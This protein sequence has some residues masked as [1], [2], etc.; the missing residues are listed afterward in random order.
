MPFKEKSA[1]LVEVQPVSTRLVSVRIKGLTPLICHQ[2]SEKAK[3]EILDKQQKKAK[4]AKRARVPVEDFIDSLYWISG[5][6]SECTEEAFEQAVENGARFGFP[7]LSIKA[8]AISGVYRSGMVKNK[9]SVQG[10][11]FIRPDAIVDGM[12]LV[13]VKG[14][15]PSIREDMVR[16]GM[17]TADLRYR[18]EF[19]EWYVDLK[20]EHN[21][22]SAFSL[23]QI[24]NMLNVGGYTVGIG[25]WRV[26]KGGQSGMF[27]VAQAN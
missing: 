4:T 20:I 7:L 6:P 21:E 2:W 1:D 18:G 10:A 11:F 14:S 3:R 13:E 8:A 27:T 26:E 19:A 24:V 23:E 22:T 12:Q 15:I 5:K 25:E 16:V 17:G 9:T